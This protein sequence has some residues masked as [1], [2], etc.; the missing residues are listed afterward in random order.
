MNSISSEAGGVLLAQDTQ[1]DTASG[2]ERAGTLSKLG[3]KQKDTWQ[4]RIVK[5][6]FRDGLT[7]SSGWFMLDM[8]A[9][10][11]QQL[12]PAEIVSVSLCV[13][14]GV[15]NAFEVVS[16]VKGNKVYKFKAESEED[17][18]AWVWEIQ[19]CIDAH[20]QLPGARPQQISVA[21]MWEYPPGV[22]GSKGE[23]ASSAAPA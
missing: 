17:C 12:L 2:C 4:L 11:S 5:L 10:G 21:H 9:S 19:Q 13:D 20:S 7:W 16:R 22:H 3:G 1:A 8:I 18:K 15:E 14:I 6:S 23:S